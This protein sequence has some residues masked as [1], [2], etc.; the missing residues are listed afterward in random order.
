MRSRLTTQ[1]THVAMAE[2]EEAVNG[3]GMQLGFGRKV[4]T[5]N[6]AI[7]VLVALITAFQT[8][9]HPSRH[10]FRS[11]RQLRGWSLHT[12]VLREGHAAPVPSWE[13]PFSWS[14]GTL[15]FWRCARRRCTKLLLSRATW[16]ELR[17]ALHHL[18]LRSFKAAEGLKFWKRDLYTGLPKT[19]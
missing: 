18:R 15:S 4:H 2:A 13:C 5:L 8:T 9:L 6:C 1:L 14:S 12:R 3:R 16:Q 17:P 10:R 19:V 11:R 7:P